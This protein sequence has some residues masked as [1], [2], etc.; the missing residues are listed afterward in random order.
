MP[1]VDVVAQWWWIAPAAV[2]VGAG[3]YAA[4]T[5]GRRRARRLALDA[6]LLTERDAVRHVT[7]AQA[8]ARVAKSELA[9]AQAAQGRGVWDVFAAPE[10][11]RRWQ[12]AK[13]AQRNAIVALRAA[14]AQVSAERARLS[15][16]TAPGDLPL[17]Q[18]VRR[19]DEIMSRWLEYETD[20]ASTVAFPQMTDPRHPATAAFLEAMRR[21]QHLRPDTGAIRM[22]PAD[23]RVYR[24]AVDELEAAFSAAEESALRASARRPRRD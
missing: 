17:A 10:A 3:G 21:A 11:R 16:R 4:A 2:G 5:T 22:P 9:V 19:H 13:L 24:Q 23:F 14:R 6:A 1:L 18:L 7:E 8:A 15:W 20:L 12:Q